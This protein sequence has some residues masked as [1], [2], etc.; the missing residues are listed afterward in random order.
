MRDHVSDTDA[1]RAVVQLYVDGVRSGDMALL[2]RAFHPDAQMY[3]RFNGQLVNMPIVKFIE[4]A[5]GMPPPAKSGEDYRATISAIELSGDA[6]VAT[7]KEVNFQ[8]ADF[9]DFFT[10]QHSAGEW[11][12]VNKTFNQLR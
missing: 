1:V 7:L 10:L 5:K 3:G 8:G 12:I 9:V 4:N 2:T 11:K 6:A